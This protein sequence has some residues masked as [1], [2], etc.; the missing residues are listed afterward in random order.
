VVRVNSSSCPS[1]FSAGPFSWWWFQICLARS[2]NAASKG[3][4]CTNAR[5]EK[6]TCIVSC[7]LITEP[8]VGVMAFV[9][10][11]SSLLYS[12]SR[13]SALCLVPILSV[14]PSPKVLNLTWI[15]HGQSRMLAMRI[16]CLLAGLCLLLVRLVNSS[17]AVSTCVVTWSA[18]YIEVRS[19]LM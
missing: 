5:S 8:V 9:L 17:D 4:P 11:V 14:A 19:R 18:R 3:V 16:L 2:H 13:S 15:G 10:R 6:R 12:A 7:G 1:P